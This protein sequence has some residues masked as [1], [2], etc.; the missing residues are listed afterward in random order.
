MISLYFDNFRGFHNSFLHLKQVNF[1]V[2][3]NSTGKT[4]VMSL[5]AL[6]TDRDF[7]YDGEFNTEN[8]HLG[9]FDE[10]ASP[11]SQFVRLGFGLTKGPGNQNAGISE[12][13][14]FLSFTNRQNI[15]TLTGG[16]IRSLNWEIGF[17]IVEN[18]PQFY[19]IDAPNPAFPPF[20][21]WLTQQT[22]EPNSWQPLTAYYGSASVFSWLHAISK[23]P[24]IEARGINY[25]D[26][27]PTNLGVSTSWI[28]PIRAKPKRTYDSYKVSSSA[29]GDHIP[30]L[31]KDYLATEQFGSE[32]FKAAL[33]KFGKDSGLFR[34]VSVRRFGKGKTAPFE[35][36]IGL[37]SRTYKI[38]NVGYGVA[39]VLPVLVGIL[40]RGKETLHLIQQPEVHLH[41]KAQAA[42]GSLFH[43]ITSD[44]E[45]TL[46]IETHSDYLIDRFRR[47]QGGNPSEANG[48][49]Q[50]VFFQRTKAGNQLSSIEIDKNGQYS[51]SQPK[52]FR[53]FFIK[54]EISLLGL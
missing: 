39:Q 27:S 13:Y 51:T 36:H 34:S 19:A 50:V 54:E 5:L 22:V 40:E 9:Y 23:E 28:A 8:V 6:L 44:A 10:I 32:G 29:E 3:E 11:K 37:N 4:S 49:A 31:L 47:E 15:A 30:Y 1:F 53:D 2:G 12:R 14:V 43:N 7:W 25:K 35:L 42:L 17:R 45:K 16:R 48:G 41:P 46:I 21:T 26:V 52:G 38:S 33:K 24:S 20:E 18:K